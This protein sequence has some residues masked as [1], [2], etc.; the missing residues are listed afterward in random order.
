MT[1]QKSQGTEI[2]C[3]VFSFLFRSNQFQKSLLKS[4]MLCF[5]DFSCQEKVTGVVF[6]LSPPQKVD[7]EPSSLFS[8]LLAKN[9]SIKKKNSTLPPPVLPV[10]VG[11]QHYQEREIIMFLRGRY[12]NKLLLEWSKW[13]LTHCKH[14]GKCLSVISKIN[15]HILYPTN[16]CRPFHLFSH[17]ATP[18]TAIFP[19][20]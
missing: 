12:K 3:L 19:F 2:R 20:F 9:I 18:S 17:T 13:H 16:V 8:S 15:V 4:F 14:K 6:K 11:Q 7:T 5:A 10:L 1:F